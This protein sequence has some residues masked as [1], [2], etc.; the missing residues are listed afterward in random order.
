MTEYSAPSL[1]T[2]DFA[3][4]PESAVTLLLAEDDDELRLLLAD[5]LEEIGYVVLAVR[6]GFELLEAVARHVT[7]EETFRG[8]VSDIRMPGPEG[9]FALATLREED[10]AVPVILTTAFGDEATR[11]AAERLGALAVLD[12][13][14]DLEALRTLLG[15]A[16]HTSPLK[17]SV[18][19]DSPERTPEPPAG[20]QTA[21]PWASRSR[22]ADDKGPTG[23]GR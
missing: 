4:A 12:K 6:D 20:S 3:S 11:K 16:L 2:T 22:P 1:G 9:M 21:I 7:G 8:I 17:N 5:W 10:R 23:T 14:L 18:C 13:P 15:D 19:E